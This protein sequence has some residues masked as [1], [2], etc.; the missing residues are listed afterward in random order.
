MTQAP[1]MHQNHDYDTSA[2]TVLCWALC[3]I[4]SLWGFCDLALQLQLQNCVQIL[5]KRWD[6]ALDS[7]QD[8][9][10]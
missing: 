7:L 6:A 10:V 8:R 9:T 1:K 2:R 4:V 3:G 5:S